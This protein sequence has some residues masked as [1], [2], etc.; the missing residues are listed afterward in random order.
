MISESHPSR[1]ART[2][3]LREAEGLLELATRPA[4]KL[5]LR[6]DLRHRL[7]HRALRLAMRHRP[8]ERD[9]WRRDLAIGQSLRLLRRYRAAIG[10]LWSAVGRHPD[11]PDAWLALGWCL[12]RLG[13]LD[14]AAAVLARAVD[15]IP[16]N[17]TLHF[18]FACYLAQ[19]GQAEAAVGELLWA[20]DL[21]PDLRSRLDRETDFDP[22]RLHAAYQALL[23]L[24]V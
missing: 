12:K 13:Q 19:L 1:V 17:A 7:A 8:P 16:D 21:N 11:S 3:P 4:V 2:Q 10:P 5:G 6:P 18:N 20:F 23:Q 9:A 22:I 15:A 24:P 14:R